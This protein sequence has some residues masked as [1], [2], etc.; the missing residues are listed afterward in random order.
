MLFSAPDVVME[1]R[2]VATVYLMNDA[3]HEKL[4]EDL[5]QMHE[6]IFVEESGEAKV[7]R[8]ETI[9]GIQPL[10]TDSLADRQ[11]RVKTRLNERLPYTIRV[12]KKKLETL[13]GENGYT[14]ELDYEKLFMTVRVALIRK[15]MFI[16]VSEMLEE[17]VP[18]N[19]VMDIS[20]LYNSHGL[21]SK[22]TYKELH[23]YTQK[24]VR[25]EVIE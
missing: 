15:K 11:F 8:F 4:D 21:L 19:I 23:A 17:L 24:Q 10:D 25:D 2:D 12:L 1:I 5:N 3:I 6:D 22:K 20:L 7:E 14:L 18:L 13:C 16:S 9:L